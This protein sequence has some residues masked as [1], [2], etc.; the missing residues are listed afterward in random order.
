M[1]LL[2]PLL[3]PF[4]LFCEYSKVQRVELYY[5]HRRDQT[6]PIEEVTETLK[7]FVKEGKVKQIGYSEISPSS[8]NRASSI[9]TIAAVQ[10]EY[11]LSKVSILIGQLL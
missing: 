8:L 9:H 5:I 11:S 4:D 6:V 3:V 2:L 1:F 7:G 10:S